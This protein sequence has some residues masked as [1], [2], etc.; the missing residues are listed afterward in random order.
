MIPERSEAACSNIKTILLAEDDPDDQ[1]FITHALL[2]IDNNLTIH[3]V[4]NGNEVL[5]FLDKLETAQLPQLLIMDYNLPERDGGD[6]LQ[7]LR[8]NNRY[9]QITMIV[10]STSNAPQYKIRTQQLG[11]ANYMV[12]PCTITGIENMARQMLDLCYA[13]T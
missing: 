10:W 8:Q 13:N 2:Q 7:L 6:V 1:E 11:A 9:K 5:R 4:S 12:K 3:T